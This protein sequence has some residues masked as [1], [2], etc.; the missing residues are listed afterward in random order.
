MTDLRKKA[1]KVTGRRKA[2]ARRARRGVKKRAPTT[3]SLT[4][5][6]STTKPHN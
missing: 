4:P 6:S 5:I 3:P 2:A 1:L